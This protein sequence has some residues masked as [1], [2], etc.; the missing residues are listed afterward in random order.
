MQPWYMLTNITAGPKSAVRPSKGSW[1]NSHFDPWSSLFR[2]DEFWAIVASDLGIFL[3][4]ST[5]FAAAQNVG[6]Y[7]VVWAY[8][9]PIVWVNHF[10]GESGCAPCRRSPCQWSQVL[11]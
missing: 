2:P 10:I 4:L 11:D 3:C 9:L 5:A 7:A 6:W 1:N 8:F